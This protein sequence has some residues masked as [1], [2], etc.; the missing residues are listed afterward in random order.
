[1]A[2]NVVQNYGWTTA[3]ARASA[4]YIAPKILELLK[5]L[6]AKRVMD[7]GAGNGHLC[8][9]LSENSFEVVGV[10]YDQQGVD[11]ARKSFP[12]LAFYRQGVQDDPKELGLD[13][14][15]FD[16]VVSTEVIEHLF[17]PHLLPHYARNVLKSGGHLILTT[18]YHGYLKNLALAVFGKWDHHHTALWHGGHIKFWSR[19]TL[20][21]LVE[22]EGFKVVGFHGVGRFPLFWKS[23]VL[24]AIKC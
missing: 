22:S 8:A 11:L 16:T 7:L 12:G 20:T 15:G 3:E 1:M 5:A 18:P 13:Q 24:V 10:E 2:E 14:P 6:G 19:E 9:Y 21:E 4:G 17:S 23:M